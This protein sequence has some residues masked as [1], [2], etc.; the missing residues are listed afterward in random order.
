MMKMIYDCLYLRCD[1]FDDDATGAKK[2][3]IQGCLVSVCRQS[4][5]ARGGGCLVPAGKNQSRE[6]GVTGSRLCVGEQQLGSPITAITSSC[7]AS[8]PV[9]NADTLHAITKTTDRPSSQ[10]L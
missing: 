9:T 3:S 10:Q 5:A 6:G 2:T 1:V 7:S 4:R 8:H